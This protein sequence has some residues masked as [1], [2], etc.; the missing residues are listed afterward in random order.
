[1]LIL[2]ILRDYTA[3]ILHLVIFYKCSVSLIVCPPN[4]YSLS[5]HP[6][7]PSWPLGHTSLPSFPHGILCFLPFCFHSLASH[8]CIILISLCS[9]VLVGV[10]CNVVCTKL[11]PVYILTCFL[12]YSGDCADTCFVNRSLEKEGYNGYLQKLI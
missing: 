8:A 12:K 11:G 1:M 4:L 9:S 10:F 6:L 2:H 5:I 7:Y 3:G